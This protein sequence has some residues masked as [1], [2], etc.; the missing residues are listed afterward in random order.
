MQSATSAAGDFMH[1]HVPEEPYIHTNN[2]DQDDLPSSRKMD[3][4][5]NNSNNEHGIISEQELLVEDYKTNVNIKAGPLA[6]AV[7]ALG[8]L[9]LNELPEAFNFLPDLDF[10][11]AEVEAGPGPFT[12]HCCKPTDAS[13]H[14]TAG[15]VSRHEPTILTCWKSLFATGTATGK[16]YAPFSS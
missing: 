4:D 7:H 16:E 9:D 13:W 15:Q 10:D 5:S 12:E 11:V 2:V 6:V 8:N 3:V 14:P 1:F